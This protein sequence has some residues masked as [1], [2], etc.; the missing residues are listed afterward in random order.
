MLINALGRMPVRVI[1][2]T[3]GRTRLNSLPENTVALPFVPG[4][5]VARHA[6]LVVSNGGSTTGYQALSQGTPVLGVPSNFDQFLSMQAI[7]RVG[8]GLSI[9]ARSLNEDQIKVG[10]MQLL[11]DAR[12]KQ[13]AVGV[14]QDF[15]RYPVA[16]LFPEFVERALAA[17][18]AWL[19]Q[20]P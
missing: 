10:A 18:G 6:A 9:K 4:D 19:R 16:K 14:A 8:A 1:L 5:R 20:V 15:E 3:A 12:Y 17:Q 13:N 7:E 2:A 11:N